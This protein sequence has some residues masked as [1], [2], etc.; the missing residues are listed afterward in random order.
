[1]SDPD[2]HDSISA[3]VDGFI[4]HLRLER[5]LSP[6]TIRAYSTDLAQYVLW[7]DRAG[8][9]PMTPG[10]QELRRY[11]RDMELAGYA[12]RTTSRRLSSLRSFF[13]YLE[14]CGLV[15]TNPAALLSAPR[16][17]RT[18]PRVVPDHV[19]Q[20]LLDAPDDSRPLGARDAAIL[21]LLYAS[22]MRVGELVALDVRDVDMTQGLVRIM[23]KGSRERIV[24]LHRFAVA[25]LRHYVLE[26]RPSI[27]S[28]SGEALFLG[29]TGHRFSSKGVREMIASYVEDVATAANV[30][31]HMLRH[32]FATHMLENGADL[33]TIQELL[34]H[35]A[36]ST[37]Q[38][39]T[40]LS[41][42]RLR[43]VHRDAHPR[44]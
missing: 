44:S 7:T 39:Y 35:I 11:V 38:I 13:G 14:R 12:R 18:L 41:T 10:V 37:T 26:A 19:L 23:G 15:V 16:I 32:T 20:K 33:R 28:Y 29:R 5:G 36:L 27:V 6:H 40:H 34:G 8:I 21:E 24:P 17:P 4:S 2:P 3:A 30:T 22:G 31:P 25:R 9:D 42:G 1:M 43:E